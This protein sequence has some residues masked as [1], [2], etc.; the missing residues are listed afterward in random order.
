[1]S[2]LYPSGEIKGYKYVSDLVI[3]CVVLDK[4]TS[5]T[6]LVKFEPISFAI[7]LASPFRFTA[8]FIGLDVEI[9]EEEQVTS[10]KYASK[11]CC[12][13]RPSTISWSG[14]YV[15]E[16]MGRIISVTCEINDKQVDYELGYL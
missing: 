1:V 7:R 6:L 8:P 15:L 11:S 5:D 2:N 9:D 4:E 14:E 16:V 13:F 12:T 10:K 3:W